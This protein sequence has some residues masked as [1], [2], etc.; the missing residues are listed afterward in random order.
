MKEKTTIT[1][2]CAV[3]FPIKKVFLK[4]FDTQDNNYVHYQLKEMWKNNSVYNLI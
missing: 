2:Y 4:L 1:F 3:Y